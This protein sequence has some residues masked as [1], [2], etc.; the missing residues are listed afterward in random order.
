MRTTTRMLRA[1]L[2]FVFLLEGSQTLL[3]QTNTSPTQTV[4]VGSTGEPYLIPTPTAGSTFSWTISSG[5]TIASGAGTN[6]IAVDWGSTPGGPHI[7]SVTETDVFG[8]SG[9]PVIVTVTLTDAAIANAGSP[10]IVCEGD[11]YAVISATASNYS[12]ISWSTTGTGTFTGGTT[13]SPIYTPSVADISAGNV[14]LTLTALGNSPCSDAISTM[15]LSITPAATA[16]AG[17]NANVC[18][19]DTYSPAGAIVTNN[20]GLIWTTLGDGAFNN[21]SI[22]LPDYTPGP[23]DISNGTVDIVLTAYGNSPCSDFSN[24]ITLTIIPAPTANTGGN[25]SVCA[26]IA[27]TFTTASSTNNI[28]VNWTTSGDGVFNSTTAINPVYTPGPLDIFNGTVDLTLTATGTS[29]CFDVVNTMTLTIEPAAIADAGLAASICSG[30]TH[31]ISGASASNNAGISWTSTGTGTFTGGSTLTPTY[32]P[33]AADIAAGSVTLTLTATGNAPC[34]DVISTMLLTIEPAAIADAGLAASICSGLTHTISGASA[35][36]NAGISWTST[37]TGTFTGGSTLTPTYTPSAADIA[38]GSVTLTL[39]ATGNAPCGDV[40][41]T[42][43]L[44][45]NPTPITGPIYHN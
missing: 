44:T 41:S 19:G 29:V 5:G 39:T 42:M 12:A 22:L 33:S 24:T 4:C 7:I 16:D 15:Q 45:I 8:C 14:I 18:E 28:G 1:I 6:Q 32:T 11:D 31:T 23:N 34:G 30:L 38:A 9:S 10:D 43:T 17:G 25:A 37:G 40:I 13:L 2:I 20:S 35:S 27:Y 36:N 26:G 3:A 21:S